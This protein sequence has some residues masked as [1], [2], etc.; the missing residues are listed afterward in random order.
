MSSDEVEFSVMAVAM[1]RHLKGLLSDDAKVLVADVDQD[2]L[3][4]LYLD[5]FPPGTNEVYR[6]RREYDCNCCRRFI[7]DLGAVVVV[8]AGGRVRT[9]WGFAAPGQFGPVCAALDGYVSSRPI[10]SA[11]L[12]REA[13]I[14]AARTFSNQ[15][16]TWNH[17]SFEPPSRLVVS[18]S[19]T[20]NLRLNNLRTGREVFQRSL[21]ELTPESVDTVLEL[22]AQG[23]LYRGDEWRGALTEFQQLQ[24]RFLALATERG[25]ELFTWATS[26]GP[27]VQRIRN[28]SIGTLLIDLSKDMGVEEAVRRYEAVVA[29]TNYKRPKAILTARSIQD[30]EKT[31][32][33]LGLARAL[34]R[35]FA[36]LSD[37]TINDTLFVD[38]DS[39]PR[40]GGG[41][42]FAD[43]AKAVPTSSPKAFDKVE[44][45]PLQRF[46]QDVLPSSR[47]IEVLLESRHAGNLVSLLAPQD[48]EAPSLFKW[49]NGFSWAYEGNI[50]DSMK[51]NVKAAGG[52]VDGVLRFSIQWNDGAE[53]N[54]N[55]F[56]AHCQEPTGHIFFGG[57]RV[58]SGGNLDVD[59]ICPATTRGRPAVEN[60]T[61]PNKATMKPGEY[62]FWVN[63]YS[64][65]DGRDGFSAEIEFDGQ[66]H[67]FD[68][69]R[70]TRRGENI[71]IARVR[72][73]KD[74]GF[75]IVPSMEVSRSQGRELWG[76]QAGQFHRVQIITQSPNHW[77]GEPGLGNKHLFL[78][79]S[80]CQNPGSP[81]GFYNEF[82]RPEL[83][84][85][86]RVF[87]ALGS[88]MAA[89]PSAEQLSGLGFSSTKR[90]TLV[91]R[92]TGQT[93][94]VMRV[95]L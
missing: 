9:I 80:G 74:E 3:W 72:Y 18:S 71:E 81:N 21:E 32:E 53:P 55:D 2:V 84:K 25:K 48:R 70:D 30:A 68:V 64:Y 41:S 89:A 14:G 87:E 73:S 16:D 52:K 20:R 78:L 93:S 92:V 31:V 60:I 34:P 45:V 51:E 49:S 36:Q 88:R 40:L 46:L 63:T 11:L 13:H 94:R 86:K 7:R 26:A 75:S 66:I 12:S 85:H 91:C 10:E 56:D 67:T 47:T 37:I 19:L 15:G 22:I 28:H 57:K 42:V 29:P 17:F 4:N 82:L 27:A 43:L 83:D 61:W 33:E 95:A 39:A 62:R 77:H 6:S 69:R 90:D 5:S 65:C 76:L 1:Q 23:S 38:R 24:R 50:A 59:I 44:E 35:R 54:L 58:S 79:L 8:D